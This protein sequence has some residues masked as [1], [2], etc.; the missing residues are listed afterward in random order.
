MCK[1][2]HFK[3][4]NS[5]CA[6][7]RKIEEQKI[8]EEEKR[9]RISLEEKAVMSTIIGL[10]ELAMA[11]EL[12]K[13]IVGEI[14]SFFLVS[15]RNAESRWKTGANVYDKMIDEKKSSWVCAIV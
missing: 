3:Q 11:K 13:E 5:Y 2:G 4:S 1:V 15:S 8:E 14:C 10:V 9:E 12:P 6:S 7:C